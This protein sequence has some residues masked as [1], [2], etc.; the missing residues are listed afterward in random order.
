MRFTDLVRL[1]YENLR[2]RIARTMLTVIGVVVGTCSIV[3]MMSIGI[4][5]DVSFEEMLQEM[6]DLTKIEIYNWGSS[7]DGSTVLDDKALKEIKQLDHVN[8]ATPIYTSQYFS[9]MIFAGKNDRYNADA[10]SI[11]GM[12]PAA[13][14]ALQY[15]LL[16]GEYLKGKSKKIPKSNEIEVLVGENA[17][18]NFTDSKKSGDKAYRYQGQF[19]AKGNQV[20]PFVDI[21][22]DDM[23]LVTSVTDH[24]SGESKLGT[25]YDLSVV[26]VMKEDYAKGQATGSGIV[27]DINILKELEK[28]YLKENGIKNSS[29]QKGYQNVTVQVD[30]MDNVTIVEEQ[31]SEMGYSTSSLNSLREDMQAQSQ[32][33]QLVLGGLGAVSLFVAALSITNTMTMAIYERTREIGVMKV[34][35]CGLGKIR[36]MFLIEAGLIGFTGGF[37]GIIV[38]HL[39]SSLI[40]SVVPMMMGGAGTRVSVIPLWLTIAGLLF[41]TF[42]GLVSGI[43]P[44]NRAV[45]ISALEA[46]RHE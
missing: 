8:I 33:I 45:K 46:I 40:N 21:V 32:V 1:C 17:G 3:V 31:I 6:G 19:D 9:A 2:R 11:T 29:V 12:E 13:I 30:E 44:A 4:A 20:P 34:L 39:L 26:G 15:E 25:E 16:D 27:M 14:Q 10:Y 38:S 22:K 18:Y 43:M 24:D 41:S 35:G 5:M 42:I 23:T 28:A 7:S 36:Q 37:L